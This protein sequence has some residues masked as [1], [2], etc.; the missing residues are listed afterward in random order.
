[1]E[2][3]HMNEI[4]T[5][6][7]E[8]VGH[9]YSIRFPRQGY[10]S[11]VGIIETANGSYALKRTKGEFFG[12]WLGK[13]VTMINLLSR[14]T[15][16]PLPVVRR[17]LVDKNKCQSWA[18]LD[19]LEG[20]T[21]RT[22]LF[23][24]KTA[25]KRKE[26]IFNFGKTL[27]HIHLTP[28]PQEFKQEQPWLDQMLEQAE[29][30]LKHG[31]VDGTEQL[32]ERMKMNRPAEYKQTLIH[33]DYTIDNVLVKNGTITG[34]ID[35]GGGAYGDPR[36]DAS[37]A[38]RPKPHAFENEVDQQIFFEGYGGKIITP[39]EYDFFVNGLYDFF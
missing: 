1:L 10:T 2:P 30:N 19:F 9:I 37:L 25:E 24:E 5:E 11:N 13:E 6:I 7:K 32:L 28:W 27:S 15:S 3:I 14:E 22:A 8:Y 12:S 31:R 36:Y 4:P 35:W 38:I 34:V 17:Y 23:N 16:L 18:L 20:E 29:F 21:L 39:K 33:G 26:M